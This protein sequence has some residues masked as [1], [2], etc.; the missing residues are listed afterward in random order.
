MKV[1]LLVKPRAKTNAVEAV[2]RTTL[3]VR[4]KAAPVEGKANQ[5][6]IALVAGYFHVPKSRVL[7]LS[8]LRGKRKVVD[9]QL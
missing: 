4:V 1:T 9:V 5:A 8:G 7:L 6:V 3:T 2:D